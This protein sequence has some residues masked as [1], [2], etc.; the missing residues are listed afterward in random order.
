MTGLYDLYTLFLGSSGVTTD[1]RRVGKGNI[2]FALRGDNFD[3]NRYAAQALE[4]GALAV[5]VDDP[6]VAGTIDG[7]CFLVEDVLTALGQLAAHHRRELAVPLLAITGSNGKTTTKELLDR[8]LSKKFRTS[9]TK[10]NLNNHIGVP[11]TLLA[12]ESH[13]EFAIVE[14]GASHQGEI[15]EL[16]RIAAPDF[17]LITNIGRAHLEGFGGA[18]GVKKGKGELFDYLYGSGGTAFYLADS[19]ELSSMVAER[20]GL[21]TVA[22]DT[23]AMVPA[24]E[25]DFLRVEM[26]DMDLRTNMVGDYNIYNVAAAFAVGRY[27]G[28]PDGDIAY[29]VEDYKPDNNR[30]QRTVTARNTVIMDAYNANPSSMRAALTNFASGSDSLPKTVILGD[31]RELGEYS[32]AEHSS[33]LELV[34]SLSILEV[35]LV[36]AEFAAVSEGRYH[37]FADTDA[38]AMFLSANTISGRSILVKGSRGIGLEK[39]FDL[40]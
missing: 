38:L 4:A 17:G 11:L 28:I 39:I 35:Y 10:G 15:R 36:G 18:E 37:S 1:S 34:S 5:V 19:P 32:A 21:R 7:R 27:F 33:I 24:K 22:Y 31:M 9:A 23:A 40:L 8:T 30:S 20:A 2:F 16:C 13:T 26:G 6:S 29:A 12:M 3:G 14:M 25:G